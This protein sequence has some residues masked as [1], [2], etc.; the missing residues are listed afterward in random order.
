MNAIKFETATVYASHNYQLQLSPET[1]IRQL[2]RYLTDNEPH[3]NTK[4]LE[5]ATPISSEGQ[6]QDIGLQAGDRV[7]LFSQP[8]RFIELPAPLRPGDKILKFSS[9]DFEMRIHSKRGVLI[10]KPDENRQL[11]PDVD[12]RYFIASDDIDY[13]SRQC[14]LLS[15]DP[16]TQVWY[17]TRAGQT[18]I[19]VNEFELTEERL[20]LNA[21]QVIRFY[22]G[23]DDSLQM[24]PIGEM[25]ISLETASMQQNTS[26]FTIG[27]REIPICIGS[28]HNRQTIRASETLPI[29]QIIRRI[30]EH[31]GRSLTP[32]L[33]V[34]R[35][36]LIPPG[37]ALSQIELNDASFLYAGANMN[38]AQNFLL[39]TDIHNRDRVYTISAGA[40]DEE[41][42]IGCRLQ[43]HALDRALDV[44][45]YDALIIRGHDPH[46]FKKI[47]QQQGRIL[48]RAGERTW[49]MKAEENAQS[50]MFI[51]NTRITSNQPTQLLSGDVFTLGPSVDHY[52]AR[53]ELQIMMK[54]Q[55]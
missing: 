2:S 41:K 10:G 16:Q 30:L 1:Q 21:H 15:F 26:H 14:L 13:I 43:G 25:H 55:V 5:V 39:L 23:S 4:T 54:T 42:R 29:K 20:P 34:Y 36:R 35:V 52:Y 50:Q 46:I 44:D 48:Y 9:G 31:Q 40:E 33:S 6:L 37:A 19:M 7:M 47:S 22:R 38:Y 17:A 18:R 8:T 24:L 51:N 3:I 45:L 27:E 28:E 32:S 11:T 12:L 49:W 53:L